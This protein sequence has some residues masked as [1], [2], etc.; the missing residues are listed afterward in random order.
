MDFDRFVVTINEEGCMWLWGEAAG[1]KQCLGNVPVAMAEALRIDFRTG[2][3]PRSIDV[4]AKIMA[5]R[6]AS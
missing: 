4:T 1:E 3:G 6:E 2:N 5:A